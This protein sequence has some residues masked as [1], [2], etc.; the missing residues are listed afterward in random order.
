MGV[1]RRG[2][3]PSDRRSRLPLAPGLVVAALGTGCAWA[4]H[5][6]ADALN[7]LTAAV[8]LG[9]V[10]RAVHPVPRWA[11]AGMSFA[12]R[13]LLQA[14]VVLLG[15]RLSLGDVLD[16]GGLTALVVIGIVAVSFLGTQLISRLAGLPPAM[17]LFIATGYS[18]C[19]VSAIVAMSGTRKHEEEDVATAV[20]LVTLCGSLAIVVLPLLRAP[21][22]LSEEEFGLWVGAS[23]HDVGQVVATA[24][25]VSSAALTVAVVIKL[26]RV[27]MLAP[28]VA[29]AAV[30]ARRVARQQVGLAVGPGPG[31]PLFV[32]GFLA[33]VGLRSA[34]DVSP[35]LLE[36]AQLVQTVLL[37]AALFCLGAAVDLRRL[38]A[39]GRRAAAVGVVSWALVAAVALGAVYA[40]R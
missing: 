34:V 32:V 1:R 3:P 9:V 13:R 8:L 18:I 5:Q 23:V 19:G 11:E 38:A 15:L 25:G 4:L 26:V 17:S 27:L 37:A 28:M 10:V 29:V 14:G 36:T 24:G 16:L 7:V 30:A 33:M 35:A 6:W 22:G 12:M 2:S 20:A 31:V 21:L 39:T 40:L